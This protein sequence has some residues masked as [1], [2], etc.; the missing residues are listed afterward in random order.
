MLRLEIAFPSVWGFEN[1]C[2]ILSQVA[3]VLPEESTLR[4]MSILTTMLKRATSFLAVESTDCD[5]LF[6]IAFFLSSWVLD[7]QRN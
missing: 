1:D 7:S 3:L 5:L 2:A 6:R 4:E